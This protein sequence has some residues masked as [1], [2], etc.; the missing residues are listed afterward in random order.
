M[1]VSMVTVSIMAALAPVGTGCSSQQDDGVSE[2]EVM[3]DTLQRQL[4]L[5]NVR[6]SSQPRAT[7]YSESI[8]A[9]L[10]ELARRVAA[11]DKE[12][13]TLLGPRT[14]SWRYNT[15]A[16]RRPEKKQSWDSQLVSTG[17]PHPARAAAVYRCCS[18]I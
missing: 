18:A 16:E 6:E 14:S 4:L 12:K 17:R 1:R 3:L 13:S 9:N 8:Q 11:K 2:C 7:L 10:N 15:G 5:I